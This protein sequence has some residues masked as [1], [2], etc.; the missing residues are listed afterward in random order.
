MKKLISLIVPLLLA[1]SAVAAT[2]DLGV[3]YVNHYV[4]NGLSSAENAAV[5]D[6]SVAKSYKLVDV[7][8]KAVLLPTSDQHTQ[9]HWYAGLGHT[10]DLNQSKSVGLRFDVG[11]YRRQ[12]SDGLQ[13]STQV[14]GGVT[15]VNPIVNLYGSYNYDVDTEQKGFNVGVNRPFVVG[16]LFTATPSVDYWSF[17]AY[18]TFRARLNISRVL[19]KTLEVYG[20]VGYL[21][22][23]VEFNDVKNLV[24]N[25]GGDIVWGGGLRYRF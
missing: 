22:N 19:W 1:G 17:N 11:A 25:I 7:S 23:S 6:L 18:D 14:E 21:T 3:G 15:L 4:V 16:K 20:E 13:S 9:S 2:G 10:F 24:K 8:A 12:L 5:V